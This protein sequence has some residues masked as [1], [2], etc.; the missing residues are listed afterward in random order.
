MRKLLF[1]AL[2]LLLIAG[3]IGAGYFRHVHEPRTSSRTVASAPQGATRSAQPQTTT[4]PTQSRPSA[5]QPA[6]QQFSGFQLFDTIV[7]VLNVVVGL[8][9]IWMAVV[10]MRMQRAAAAAMERRK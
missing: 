6:S 1:L 4:R 3:A 7:N 8:V 10:G 2:G 9:G 5:Q